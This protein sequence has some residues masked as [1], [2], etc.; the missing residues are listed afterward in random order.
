MQLLERAI[1]EG[2]T[3]QGPWHSWFQ[4]V[5]AHRCLQEKAPK[6]LVDCC[7]TVLE[8]AGVSHHFTVPRYRLN[9]FGPFRSLVL[10]RGTLYQIVSSTQHW[11][12][13]FQETT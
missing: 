11:V 9:T 2:R 13:K 1:P 12:L 6:Y 3:A 8:V 5:T 10:L 4:C 7:T